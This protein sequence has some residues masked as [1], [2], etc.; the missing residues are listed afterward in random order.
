MRRRTSQPGTS[1]GFGLQLV[2]GRD[3]MLC[4]LLVPVLNVRSGPGLQYE[5]IAKVRGTETEVGTVLII[6]RDVTFEWLAVDEVVAPGGWITGSANFVAC[7]GAISDLP[8][9][10]ITDGRL[11][12]VAP[13]EAEA[14]S[15][16]WRDRA[17]R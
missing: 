5:I 12:P 16:R 9:A 6:G 10:E 3:Q 13:A 15:D 11:A 7:D 4:T 2:I 14:S 8:V 1:P 17:G